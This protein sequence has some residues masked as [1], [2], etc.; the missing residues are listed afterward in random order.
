MPQ[1]AALGRRRHVCVLG[2]R[3][4]LRCVPLCALIWRRPEECRGRACK[5]AATQSASGR[6]LRAAHGRTR[7]VCVVGARGAG[8]APPLCAAVALRCAT[9]DRQSSRAVL[10]RRHAALALLARRHACLQQRSACAGMRAGAAAHRSGASRAPCP[11]GRLGCGERPSRP[12][13]RPPRRRRGRV[14]LLDGAGQRGRDC[15]SAVTCQCRHSSVCAPRPAPPLLLHGAQ[16]AAAGRQRARLARWG[17][18]TIACLACSRHVTHACAP[19]VGVL[20]PSGCSAPS[21][22]SPTRPTAR[23]SR[24]PQPRRAL[25]VAACCARAAAKRAHR[26]CARDYY[27][28]EAHSAGR[29]C[30]AAVWAARYEAAAPV[31]GRACLHL[32]ACCGPCGPQRARAR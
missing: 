22:P 20:V 3:C 6:A 16:P 5:P 11:R 19:A 21:A 31:G 15:L 27:L 24:S 10:Q 26:A 17:W 13:A 14:R 18:L 4:A 1:R 7:T 9:S 30:A 32:G 2:V 28:P 23:R 12:A 29:A 25:S 8:T